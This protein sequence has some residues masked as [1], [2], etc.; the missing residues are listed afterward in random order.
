VPG[1]GGLLI[2]CAAGIRVGYRQAKAGLA[3]R[4]SGIARFAGP[5]PM[6]VVRSGS[7][8]AL[9]SRTPRLGRPHGIRAVREET[10]SAPLLLESVA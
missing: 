2:V 3:L 8:I 7:L 4:A 1:I 6:G 10:A 5:G 9:H